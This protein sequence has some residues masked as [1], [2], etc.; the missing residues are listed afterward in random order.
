MSRYVVLVNSVMSAPAANTFAPPQTTTA[1]ISGSSAA[2]V[3]A[4]RNSSWT[5][6]F[7]AFIGG[8]SSRIVADAIG[9]LQTYELTHAAP[10]PYDV[11]ASV[12]PGK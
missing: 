1:R 7:S 12:R 10:P 11:P 9:G 3:A 5:W 8:R 4:A 6:V 2:A